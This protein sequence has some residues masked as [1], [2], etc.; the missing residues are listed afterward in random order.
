MR[1]G[2]LIEG[3]IGFSS[4]PS[5]ISRVIKWFTKSRWSHCFVVWRVIGPADDDVLLIEAG[6]FQVQIV[7]LGKYMRGNYE[8][9]ILDVSS[10]INSEKKKEADKKLVSKVETLYGWLQLIGFGIVILLRKWFGWKSKKNIWGRGKICS[11]VVAEYLIDCGAD[12]K[13]LCGDKD[14]NLISPEDIYKFLKSRNCNVIM[15]KEI[16]KK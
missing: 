9:E 11:E 6:E 8:F 14:I 12:Q 15:K 1:M 7:T 13:S 5:W 2:Y 10:L 16:N 4:S 3:A